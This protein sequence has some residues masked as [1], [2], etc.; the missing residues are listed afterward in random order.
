MSPLHILHLEDNPTDGELV[1]SVL[2]AAGLACAIERVETRAEFQKALE[3]AR[4]DLIISDFTLPSFDGMSALEMARQ[5]SPG[6]PFVFVSGTMGE[7]VAVDSLKQ[8]ASDYVLK[9]R[10]SR[11]IP[12][13]Q[14]ARREAQERAE[15]RRIGEELRQR[16]ELFR[17]ISDNVD[18]LIVVLDSGGRRHYCSRSYLRL[19]GD[20]NASGV[21][22]FFAE[23]HPADRERLQ[24]VFHKTVS[25]G[26][27]MRA[28]YRILLEDGS[29]RDIE[30]QTSV[31][32]AAEG[33][34]QN[35]V[36]V[37]RDVTD[38]KAAEQA[39]V[40]A[41]TKFRT[42]V[43]QSIVGIYIVQEGALLYVNPK[44]GELFGS[45]AEEM[46]SRP[47]LDFV[48][49]EDRGLARENMLQRLEG[50]A[51][52][53]PFLL[54][55]RRAD[56]KV[57]H[58]EVHGGRTEYNGRAAI[59]GT[60]LDIT[61]KKQIEAQLLR[62]QRLENIG[63]LA[64]GI[65]HDLNNVLGPILVVGHLLRDKLPS[66]EDRRMLDT[67]AA[68]AQRGAEMV[69]QILSFARGVSGEPV[70]L[71]VKHLVNEIVRLARET[72]PRSIHITTRIPDRLRAIIG[73]ATQVHQVLL[74]LCVNARDAM[75]E[76]GTLALEAD[77]TLLEG[78]KS[79]MQEQPLSGPFVVLCVS[80]TGTGIPADLLD[81]I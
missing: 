3:Q 17:Q 8:G 57:M 20:P 13:V 40:A 9:D 70:L 73:D 78:V 44:M 55:M 63:V 4:F 64:G 58:A 38:R 56:G 22:D 46:I 61:E 5:K 62:A 79:K 42:L 11:L 33:R 35:V 76:G 65:A 16:N 21:T 48:V 28:E 2:E 19:L 47:W 6:I 50:A 36:I 69:K 54:R 18:D 27:G 24:H 43:E 81:K 41:E 45:A 14:R 37:A 29:I 77:T 51:P 34:V 10:L 59:I 1:Q 25:E 67:A 15:R 72:F 68:S 7:E 30:S 39:L 31:I 66:D 74:N 49:E 12:S 26:T 52:S 60:L 32:R 53:A 75:P 80:D 71:Q 23:I